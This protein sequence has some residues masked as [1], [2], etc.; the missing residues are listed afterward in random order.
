MSCD[1]GRRCSKDLVLLWLWSRLAAAAPIWILAWEPQY[2]MGIALKKKKK[3]KS[4]FI[5]PAP[6][7]PYQNSWGCQ[8]SKARVSLSSTPESTVY[9]PFPP[10][11]H[12]LSSCHSSFL[13]SFKYF[14]M[15]LLN[16]YLQVLLH[17]SFSVGLTFPLLQ[18][19][20]MLCLIKAWWYGYFVYLIM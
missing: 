10:Q 14:N 1:V 15:Y 20:Y 9:S 6:D 4:I 3:E 17:I 13:G 7:L 19:N 18:L 5:D 2:A 11:R 8:P 16:I 12:V